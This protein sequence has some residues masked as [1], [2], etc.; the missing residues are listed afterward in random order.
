PTP[1]YNVGEVLNAGF[2]VQDLFVQV[3]VII[4][5]KS[6]LP[7]QIHDRRRRPFT[8]LRQGNRVGRHAR[9]S[10]DPSRRNTSFL[11]IKWE[12]LVRQFRSK[13]D[14]HPAVTVT[15]GR[16]N[17]ISQLKEVTMARPYLPSFFGRGR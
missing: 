7:R 17:P 1:L 9:P 2:D 14:P 13:I 8:V 5:L 12:F 15:T 4:H 16:P 3:T 11:P 6:T 10:S